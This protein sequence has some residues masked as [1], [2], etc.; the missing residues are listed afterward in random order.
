MQRLQVKRETTNSRVRKRGQSGGIKLKSGKKRGKSGPSLPVKEHLADLNKGGISSRSSAIMSL[1]ALSVQCTD[2]L[3]ALLVPLSSL[4]TIEDFFHLNC[5]PGDQTIGAAESKCQI[6]LLFS[7][8]LSCYQ[9][10]VNVPDSLRLCWGHILTEHNVRNVDSCFR[11][12]DR[13]FNNDQ[14]V[15]QAGRVGKGYDKQLKE[16][17]DAEIL[18]MAQEFDK[19][20]NNDTVYEER[21]QTAADNFI[22]AASKLPRVSGCF[23]PCGFQSTGAVYNCITCQYDSCKF[24]LDCP[25]KE[26]K[27][28]ENSR[29]RMWCDVLFPLPNGIEIIWRFAEEVK[30]Q[31]VDQFQEVTAGVDKLYSIPSTSLQHQGTY[32]CEI[33]SG[34]RSIVRLYYF[35]TVTPQFVAG[36]TELQEIFDLSLLPGGRLLTAPGG[37]LHSP[38]L[39]PSSLLLTGSALVFS[40]SGNMS[41]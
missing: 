41:C 29:I 6:S 11:K 1:A 13:I 36:H 5:E 17:L 25:V 18:P 37:P 30:T 10:F 39:L 33:Y 35:L 32:Q 26:I 20:L 38:L 15:I 28:T 3:Y 16:I 14:R 2:V 40:T 22:A 24:P 7:T 9:C 4:K 31:Q 8:S 12:L 23:P 27:V 21:L 34:Q 19:K